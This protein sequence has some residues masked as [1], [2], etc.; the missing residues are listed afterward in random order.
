MR[1]LIK[2]FHF[3]SDMLEQ[4][5]PVALLGGCVA[6]GLGFLFG[7]TLIIVTGAIIVLLVAA[8]LIFK[9]FFRR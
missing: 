9:Y 4:G 8:D 2:D 3:L 1:H 6:I 7:K 5:G